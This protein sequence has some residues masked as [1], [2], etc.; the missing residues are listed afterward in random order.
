MA[1][2]TLSCASVRL[3]LFSYLPTW[4][5]V[6][7]NAAAWVFKSVFGNKIEEKF[8][9]GENKLRRR[10]I[11]QIEVNFYMPNGHGQVSII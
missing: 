11:P 6:K 7:L 9:N 4:I 8:L 10:S 2:A 1:N 3:G 5:A